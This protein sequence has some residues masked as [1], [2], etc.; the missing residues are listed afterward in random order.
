MTENTLLTALYAVACFRA[1]CVEA[2]QRR[3]ADE[4]FQEIKAAVLKDKGKR[5]D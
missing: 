1:S 4:A 2:D 3:R 5:D